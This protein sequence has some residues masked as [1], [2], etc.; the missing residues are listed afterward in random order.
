MID[1]W[2]NS[3]STELRSRIIWGVGLG[4]LLSF[5]ILAAPQTLIFLVAIVLALIAWREYA[6]M[7]SIK[8]RQ[9]FYYIGYLYI[10]L[11]FSHTFFAGPVLAFWM[12]FVW[13]S[14]F[15]IIFFEARFGQEYE[16]M[17]NWTDLCRFVLGL[18]YI[19]MIFGFCAPLVNKPH[20]E[21]LL[22]LAC[23]VVFAG[24]TGAYF[25][26]KKYGK[27]KLWPSLSPGKTVEGAIGGWIASF[28]A[29]FLLWAIFKLTLGVKSRELSLGFFVFVGLF[30]PPL[31]QAG[32]FLESLMKRAAGF[33]DSGSLLPGHGGILDRVDGLVWVIPLLYFLS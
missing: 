30:I 12:W 33:K 10:V 25:V 18:L 14:G 27:Q 19:F 16:P 5:I 17:K 1:S 28:V 32:D 20:G 3:L 9:S 24:D 21:K 7:M 6:R 11:M 4:V 22:Y 31:A 8:D 26:G 2:L 23:V 29:A 13:V 15:F